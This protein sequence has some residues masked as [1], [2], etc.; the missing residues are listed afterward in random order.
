MV[1]EEL[2]DKLPEL[3]IPRLLRRQQIPGGIHVGS[4]FPFGFSFTDGVQAE[5]NRGCDD[6]IFDKKLRVLLSST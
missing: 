4:V 3:L 5:S 6:G 1:L 2:D